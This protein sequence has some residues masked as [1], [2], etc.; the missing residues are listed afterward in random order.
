M[1]VNFHFY[2]GFAWPY[3]MY[4]Y[5]PLICIQVEVISIN[6]PLRIRARIYSIFN[7]TKLYEIFI[8]KRRAQRQKKRTKK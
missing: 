6:I 5:F 4:E 8:N 7:N 2:L 1:L 3:I